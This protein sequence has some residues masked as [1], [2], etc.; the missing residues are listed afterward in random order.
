[1]FF[2][3]LPRETISAIKSGKCIDRPNPDAPDARTR[4]LI[5]RLW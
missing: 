4:V 3:L 2:T 1:L 5:G